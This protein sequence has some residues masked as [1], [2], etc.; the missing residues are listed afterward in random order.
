[1]IIMRNKE[2]FKQ[3]IEALNTSKQ[4]LIFP[5][6]NPDGDAIGSAAALYKALIYTGK[7]VHIFVE[8]LMPQYL[9]FLSEGCIYELPNDFNPD[10]CI[11]VDC[12]DIGRLGK[13]FEPYSKGKKTINIDH[14]F[15][16]TFF[17]DINYIDDNAGANG[18]IVYEFLKALNVEIDKYMAEA[19]YTAISTDTGSF[20]YSNTTQNTHLVAAE[21]LNRGVDLNHISVELYQNIR[22]EKIRLEAKVLDN[23][24]IFANGQAVSAYVSQK[25]LTETGGKMDETEGIIE[26]LR[27]IQG[28][29]IA[30]LFKEMDEHDIKV[31]FRAK[32]SADVSKI[33]MNFDGG[34]HVKAAGCSFNESL[35]N[36]E[37]LVSNAVIDY[38]NTIEK[39]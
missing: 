38:L 10:L 34:G 9:Q 35:E 7:D 33:A 4:I 39:E 20:K 12:S 36:V 13:R 24:S 23:L 5:H 18:E 22:L 26:T 32:K 16:N 19:L 17:A 21:L 30:V 15:T 1:M 31:S 2:T 8:E 29:E 28:V 6:I 37:Q 11:A 14:H 3:I 25:I 27:N